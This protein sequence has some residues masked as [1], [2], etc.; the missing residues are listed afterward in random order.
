MAKKITVLGSTGSVGIQTLEVARNLKLEVAGLTAASN[1]DLLEKQ[2]REFRP[3]AV[4]LKNI[5]FI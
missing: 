4:A 3:S 1:I 5:L 2:A